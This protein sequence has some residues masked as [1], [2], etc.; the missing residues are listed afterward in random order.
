MRLQSE[1]APDPADGHAAQSGCL[2]QFPRAPVCLPAR[3]A[4]QSLNHH[5]FNLLVADLARRAG[6][7]FI[8]ESF[9]PHLQESSSPFAHHAQR[10]AQLAGYRVIVQTLAT[11]QH[12]ARPSRQQRLAPR[13]MSH[14]F[15]SGSL[16]FGQQQRLL[17]RPV[18]IRPPAF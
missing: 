3:R 16:F 14:R 17:G 6:P 18:R 10:A 7:W 2:R 8:I 5:P 12:D 1:G 13:P 9:Q 15:E 11:G 4:F